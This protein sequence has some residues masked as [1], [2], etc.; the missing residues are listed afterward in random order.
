MNKIL[1]LDIGDV[2][3]GTAL[4]DAL[5]ILAKPLQTIK[6]DQLIDF[7]KTITAKEQITTIIIGNP[8]TLKG[9]DSQQTKKVAQTT[10]ALK[11]TFPELSFILWDERL[12]SKRAESLQKAISK[13]EKIK[14]HSR[15][16]AF[17]LD[18]YLIYKKGTLY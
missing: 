17:I 11:T 16:A 2:W 5:Q 18:S 8:R 14:S 10:E 4:S 6:A 3:V 9:T 1:A 7:I 12:S 15:A 13:E